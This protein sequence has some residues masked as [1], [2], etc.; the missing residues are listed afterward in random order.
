MN[1]LELCPRSEKDCFCGECRLPFLLL[2]DS[3][4]RE[5]CLDC[6]VRLGCPAL[7]CDRCRR[8]IVPGDRCHLEWGVF[9]RDCAKQRTYDDDG[10]YRLN[11]HGWSDPEATEG[12]WPYQLTTPILK[13]Q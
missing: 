8:G 12:I 10:P 2:V 6:F 1:G 4:R 3:P 9:C 11:S 13:G 5:L 7:V